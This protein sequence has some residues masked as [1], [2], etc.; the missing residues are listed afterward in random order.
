MADNKQGP[1]QVTGQ[2][3]ACPPSPDAACYTNQ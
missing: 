2:L 1:S 3:K